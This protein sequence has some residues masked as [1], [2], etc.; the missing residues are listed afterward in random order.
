MTLQLPSARCADAEADRSRMRLDNVILDAADRGDRELMRVHTAT[1]RVSLNVSMTVGT[2]GTG[3]R[4]DGSAHP[5]VT[6]AA[7]RTAKE[8]ASSVLSL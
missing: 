2:A 1:S 4:R 5:A 8:S 7:P 3:G 6:S